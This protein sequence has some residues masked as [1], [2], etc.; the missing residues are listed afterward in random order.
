MMK[1]NTTMRITA[2][3]IAAVFSSFVCR[4]I[5]F[6][7]NLFFIYLVWIIKIKLSRGCFSQTTVRK[8]GICFITKVIPKESI[9]VNVM[10]SATPNTIYGE[11][12]LVMP[13]IL[14]RIS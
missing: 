4:G 11:E 7:L 5:T 10:T 2:K 6:V 12:R 9:S 14:P 1:R 8:Y 3:A 13:S